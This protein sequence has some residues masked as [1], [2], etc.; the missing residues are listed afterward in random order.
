MSASV[1]TGLP[2]P[3]LH[4][5]S[6]T[7]GPP[8]QAA[9]SPS[10]AINPSESLAAL[11][12]VR[13]EFQIGLNRVDNSGALN[14]AMHGEGAQ[15]G[16]FDEAVRVDGPG[17]L[18]RNKT[19]VRAS[20]IAEIRERIGLDQS[21]VCERR[22]GGQG[23]EWVKP[24]AMRRFTMSAPPALRA[25]LAPLRKLLNARSK[26]T[27]GEATRFGPHEQSR[28][29]PSRLVVRRGFGLGVERPAPPVLS[30]SGARQTRPNRQGR[31]ASSPRSAP[32]G[33]SR[34]TPA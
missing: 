16:Q 4:L 14:K 10:G 29:A 19:A 24:R 20:P 34:S 31:R 2:P 30:S 18:A 15:V 11:R 3:G 32:R 8:L 27:P 25:R 17:K 23:D 1:E 7:E 21:R 26:S 5:R 12:V 33:C 13:K 9:L 6:R 22:E 28:G